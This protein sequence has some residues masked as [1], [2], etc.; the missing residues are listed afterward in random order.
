MSLVVVLVLACAPRPPAPATA[1]EAAPPPV[2]SAVAF[3]RVPL[4]LDPSEITYDEAGKTARF[5]PGG[6]RQS[7]SYT[8]Y[9]LD[10]PSLEATLGG[11]PTAP[12]AVIVEVGPEVVTRSTPTDPNLPAPDGGFT[13][14]TRTGRVA[15]RAK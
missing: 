1:P 10:L 11:R 7:A 2:V 4:T 8:T 6:G 9:V 5:T 14:T 3:E 13:F 12:V 15:E